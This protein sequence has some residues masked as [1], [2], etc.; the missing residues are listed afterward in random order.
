M[1]AELT[2]RR[3]EAADFDS[4]FQLLEEVAIEGRWIGTEAPVQR[5]WFHESFHS[6]L[7]S[8]RAARFVAAIDGHLV[9]ELGVHR[10]A[11]VADLGMMVRQGHRGRGIGSALIE[12]CIDWSRNNRA[13]KVTLTVFPHNAAGLALY[14]KHGF[15]EEGRL[16]RH[17]RRRTGQLWDAIPM[18]LVLDHVT[19]GSPYDDADA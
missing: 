7:D 5:E 17:W 15:T 12:A 10:Q 3:A 11:G 1:S 19:P 14:R 4:W 16:V 18:G 13:H 2:V 9:G 6:S 8:D